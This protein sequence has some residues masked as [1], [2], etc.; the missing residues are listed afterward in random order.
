MWRVSSWLHSIAWTALDCE[1]RANPPIARVSP[2]EARAALC[3]ASRLHTRPDMEH[4]FTD[5]K[6]TGAH[7][8]IRWAWLA[9]LATSSEVL[10]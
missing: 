10:P 7:S 9:R 3:S 6:A 5:M 4:V 1:D 2:S 8:C